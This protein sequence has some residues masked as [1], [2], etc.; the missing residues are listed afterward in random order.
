VRI[1]GEGVRARAVRIED[2][3]RFAWRGLMIDVARHFVPA[4]VLLR[5]LDAMEMVKL[6]VLHLH[7]SDSQGFR[8]ESRKY[9]RLHQVNPA[10]EFYTQAQ[11]EQTVAT[12]RDRGIRV[13][14]EFEMPGHCHA[15]LI[16]YPEL[17]SAPGPYRPGVDPAFLD[18]VLDPT[19]EGTYEFL[20]RLLGEMAQLFPDRVMHIAGDEVNG[21]QWKANGKIRDFMAAQ[22][23]RTT[24]DLQA[25]FTKRVVAIELAAGKTRM[26]WDEVLGSS[27]PRDVII[28]SWR[29]SKMTKRATAAGHSTVV[30]AG[31][32]LNNGLPAA[33]YYAAEPLDPR[34]MGLPRALLDRA[35]GTPL[36]PYVT[37]AMVSSDA[38]DL[39]QEERSLVLGG[40]V[41]MWTELCSWDRLELDVW[42][43]A[44][45]VA[46]RLWSPASALN[47]SSLDMRLERLDGDLQL[48]GLMHHALQARRL[49]QLAGDGPVEPVQLLA[50]LVEPTKNLARLRPIMMAM[51]TQPPGGDYFPPYTRFVDALAP[52]SATARRL[53]AMV[54]AALA[55]G[56]A[57]SPS[58]LALRSLLQQWRDNDDEFQ[59][60]ARGSAALR[61]M[62]PVSH[63]V[64]ELGKAGLDALDA[65]ESRQPLA[66][67]RLASGRDLIE[68]HE[69]LAAASGDAVSAF[70]TPQPPH[71]VLIAIVPSVKLLVEAATTKHRSL[72]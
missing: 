67:E 60:T 3:P 5:S 52:E 71:D 65:I 63:D 48:Q 42:P 12:A 2:T 72:V 30:S 38:L 54:R 15:M 1:D 69:R 62:L 56:T 51:F 57:P 11:I 28:Q 27:A 64:R 31:Y 20:G 25:A 14:P 35:K 26:A 22:G 4:D 7:L 70:T 45:A 53:A 19:Q 59:A 55:D 23:Y 40:E 46:E 44:G 16:A 66:G 37:D 33:T 47:P 49:R 13:L 43:R 6:D 50:G 9:P 24:Q 41:S 36:E 32:Y 18:A 10:G 39:T 21:V 34:A 58:H 61:E 8:V 29:S 17:G 68:K